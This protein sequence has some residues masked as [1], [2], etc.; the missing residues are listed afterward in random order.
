MEMECLQAIP[1]APDDENA[2]SAPF[3]GGRTIT[4]IMMAAV[5]V[6]LHTALLGILF[7]RTTSPV[8]GTA[9]MQSAPVIRVT[10]E[11]PLM[12][13]SSKK[14]S[15]PLS[16]IMASQLPDIGIRKSRQQSVDHMKTKT[17]AADF[18]VIEG[19]L[20]AIHVPHV[21]MEDAVQAEMD[22]TNAGGLDLPVKETTTAGRNKATPEAGGIASGALPRYL[23]TPAPVYP[24]EAR[25]RGYEGLVLC[26]VEVLANG[27]VGQVRIK[28]SSGF[29]CLDRSAR[30]AVR[31][32][33]F[34]P[35]RSGVASRAMTVD[36]PIRF[37]LQ[38]GH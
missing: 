26:S 19:H 37:S 1:L 5:S 8:W 34:D 14:N 25:L 28:T 20:G 7:T 29:D 31:S 12:K 15:T 17:E 24:R 4:V 3:H 23:E 6:L 10:L 16:P 9:P 2:I 27:R 13:T 35:A 32:W 21:D 36:I 38:S 30:R 11:S 18:S 22:K 33:R